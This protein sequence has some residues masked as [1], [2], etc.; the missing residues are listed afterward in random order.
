MKSISPIKNNQ[1]NS[2]NYKTKN[3]TP[4]NCNNNLN[5]YRYPNLGENAHSRQYSMFDNQIYDQVKSE[6]ENL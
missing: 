1:A 2:P 3:L 4:S 6:N 5:Y